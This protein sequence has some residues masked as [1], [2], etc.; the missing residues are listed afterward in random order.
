M[1]DNMQITTRVALEVAA[2]EAIVLQAYKDSVGVWTWSVG[3]TSATGHNVERY[4]NNPTSM[5]QALEIWLW[6]MQRYADEVR[7]AFAGRQLTDAQF[8]AALSFHW[9][10]GGISKASW[11][12]QWLAGDV[13]GARKSFMNWKKPPEIIPRRAAERDLF[14]DGKWTNKGSMMEYTKVTSRGTPNWSSGKRVDVSA[15]IAA[16]LDRHEAPVRPDV[17]PRDEIVTST[18]EGNTMPNVVYLRLLAY[19]MSTVAGLL[20]AAWAGWISYDTATQMLQISI[21]GIVTAVT[22]GLGLTGAI[23]AKFGTK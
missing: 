9:N 3:L 16:I 20:P 2:H 12:K 7:K 8:A 1:T 11:V 21:P 5:R 4:I 14:F 17:E 6:A 19:V 18:P 23:F 15:D 10:T 22:G 13:A